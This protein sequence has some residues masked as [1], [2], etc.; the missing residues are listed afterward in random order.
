[1]VNIRRLYQKK[2]SVI[3][4]DTFDRERF[5]QLTELSPLEGSHFPKQFKQPQTKLKNQRMILLN[6]C[7]EVQVQAA[8]KGK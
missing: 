5:A 1:M 3:N 7:P 4:T 2:H 8:E 6:C